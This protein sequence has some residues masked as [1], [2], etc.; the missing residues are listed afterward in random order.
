MSL[1]KRIDSAL[2]ALDRFDRDTPIAEVLEETLQIIKTLV[3]ELDTP[4]QPV[5]T[6]ALKD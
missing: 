4:D 3:V 1:V 5:T 2:T 6:T